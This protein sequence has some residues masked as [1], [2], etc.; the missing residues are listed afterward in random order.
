MDSFDRRTLKEG[1]EYYVCRICRHRTET[2]DD[3]VHHCISI[4]HDVSRAEDEISAAFLHLQKRVE[5]TYFD[6]ELLIESL[7]D[8]QAL[9]TIRNRLLKSSMD[10]LLRVIEQENET[11]EQFLDTELEPSL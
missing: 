5:D 8:N 10:R 2:E 6:I 1:E 3:M 11:I 7:V 9:V 4:H